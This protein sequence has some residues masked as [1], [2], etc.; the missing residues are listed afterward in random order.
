MLDLNFDPFPLLTTEL[1][2]LRQI[3]PA[4]GNEI[5]IQRSHPIALKYINRVPAANLEEALA[6]ITKITGLLESNES[7]IWAIVPKGEE[8]LV[9]TI[10][11]WNID[12]ELD[13]AE[14]GYGLHPDYF[15]KGIMS[16]VLSAVSNYGF[17]Q[18]KLKRI[19]AY[20]HKDNKASL[21]LL[22]KNKFLRN[23]A[24]EA[25]FEDKKELEYN[26]IHTLLPD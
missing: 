11:L 26:T 15:G 22:E 8:K 9:G 6:F 12:K 24:F 19:D 16:E 10:C 2:T 21:R 20:T 25:D 17:Q 23:H 14:T 4:D 3:I 1:F 13:R 5:F 18:M 7:V